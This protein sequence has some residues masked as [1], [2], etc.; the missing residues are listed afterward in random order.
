MD[1]LA[2]AKGLLHECEAK[3][4]TQEELARLMY[5]VFHEIIADAQDYSKCH[6]GNLHGRCLRCP[7]PD[8]R[9]MA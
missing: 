4:I 3:D 9:Y 7:E 5:A 2:K 1:H 6:H 8:L